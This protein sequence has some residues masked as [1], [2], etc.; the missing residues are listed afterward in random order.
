[1]FTKPLKAMIAKSNNKQTSRMARLA[2]KYTIL[3]WITVLSTF[4]NLLMFVIMQ[5]S[6]IVVLDLL[7]NLLCFA[8]LT[9]WYDDWYYQYCG[10]S[11]VLARCCLGFAPENDMLTARFNVIIE[12][13]EKESEYDT[14][15]KPTAAELQSRAASEGTTTATVD[16][17]PM[18]CP[19][20][21]R[22]AS[23]NQTSADDRLTVMSQ[24]QNFTE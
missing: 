6:F 20:V 18:T 4:A 12:P 14:N 22:A 19:A 11:F 7:T 3:T 24:S 5:R 13:T 16:V 9:N 21:S 8:L 1:M 10:C 17:T 2:M 15:S 23:P